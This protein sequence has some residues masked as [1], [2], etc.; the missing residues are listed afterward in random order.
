M[1]R[2]FRIPFRIPFRMLFWDTSSAAFSDTIFGALFGAK[3]ATL[4]DGLDD[5]DDADDLN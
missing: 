5:C 2:P 4:A 1:L 3:R